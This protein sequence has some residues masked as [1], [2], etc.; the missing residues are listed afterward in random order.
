LQRTFQL[1]SL[2]D[3]AIQGIRAQETKTNQSTS[4]YQWLQLGFTCPL[5]L[6]P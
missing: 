4:G 2:K 3:E 1:R 5:Q 6:K